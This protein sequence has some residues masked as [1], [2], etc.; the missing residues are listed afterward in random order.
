MFSAIIC[1]HMPIATRNASA[2]VIETVFQTQ[3]VAGI[4]GGRHEVTPPLPRVLSRAGSRHREIF[5]GTV[6]SGRAGD[7]DIPQS[8][9]EQLEPWQGQGPHTTE[10]EGIAGCCTDDGQRGAGE[11]RKTS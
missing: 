10:H 3:M 8:L 5:R 4:V 6:R 11:E 7:Q 9:E 2:L 1:Y